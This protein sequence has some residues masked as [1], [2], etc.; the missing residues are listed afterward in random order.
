MSFPLSPRQLVSMVSTH[1]PAT[2]P[3][4]Y[5][6]SSKHSPVALS[7]VLKVGTCHLQRRVRVSLVQLVIHYNGLHIL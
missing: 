3:Y 1:P 5:Y 6:Y 7:N 4:Y 2:K